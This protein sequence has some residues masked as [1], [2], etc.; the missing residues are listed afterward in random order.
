VLHRRTGLLLV[1]LAASAMV[2]LLSSTGPA[3]ANSR[4][5]TPLVGTFRLRAGDCIGYNLSGSYF[6]LIFPNGNVSTGR[7]FANPD[8]LCSNKTYTLLQSGRDGG[9]VTGLYQPGPKREFSPQGGA[10]ARAIISPLSF[11]EVNLS[12]ATSRIDPQSG[13]RVPPPAIDERD[14]RLSG[15]VEAW[16]AYWNFLDLNQGSPKPGG[17]RPGLTRALSGSYDATTRSF[18]MTWTSAVVG[19]P[20]NGFTGYWHLVGTFTPRR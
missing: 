5:R 3:G 17:R 15:Q 12:V 11:T 13:R 7:F 18:T 2:A 8:S 19:G 14:G 16:S 6:R 9:L 20:F 10:L 1:A 4:H